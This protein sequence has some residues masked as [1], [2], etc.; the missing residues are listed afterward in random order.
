MDLLN[1]ISDL[2]KIYVEDK[3]ESYYDDLIEKTITSVKTNPILGSG[4]FGNIYNVSNNKVVKVCKYSSSVMS[5]IFIL[6]NL[7]NENIL[8]SELIFMN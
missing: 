7:K 5:E 1:N 8:N 3:S 4:S 2:D 6:S